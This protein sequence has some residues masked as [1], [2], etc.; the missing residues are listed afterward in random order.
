MVHINIGKLGYEMIGP[1]GRLLRQPARPLS[2]R[3]GQLALLLPLLRFLMTCLG[4][5][6]EVGRSNFG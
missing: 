6:V 3:L 2:G 1:D 5:T 4:R